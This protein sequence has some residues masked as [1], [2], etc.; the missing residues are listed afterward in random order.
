ML[1]CWYGR[2]ERVDI[3][4]PILLLWK[5]RS[6]GFGECDGFEDGSECCGAFEE[7]IENQ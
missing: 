5:G 4:L 2:S 1:W 3:W 7:E 6:L